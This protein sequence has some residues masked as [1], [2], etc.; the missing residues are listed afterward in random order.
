MLVPTN[1]AGYA[2]DVI[3]LRSLLTGGSAN[4]FRAGGFEWLIVTA[5][6]LA[7]SAA[8]RHLDHLTAALE[9]RAGLDHQ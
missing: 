2:G 1:S 3:N 6:G 8:G 4:R 7:L 5:I 9:E